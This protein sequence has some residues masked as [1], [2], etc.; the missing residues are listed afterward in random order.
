MI[1]FGAVRLEFGTMI[2]QAA[3]FIVLLL[4]VSKFAMKPVREMFKQRQEHIE[5]EIKA[6][7]LARERAEE[8]MEK[9]KKALEAARDEAYQIVANA[10][11]QAELQGDK[12]L[13]NAEEQANRS[14][15]EARAEIEREREKAVAALREQTAELSVMLASKII[16]KELDKKEQQA[17]IDEFLKQV[18][19]RI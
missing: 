19:D 10:K 5:N 3:V 18:G 2:F 17:E 16:E 1:D 15:Q 9:Q 8:S 12:V 4:L 7:E 14:L 13:K 6:A 11:K